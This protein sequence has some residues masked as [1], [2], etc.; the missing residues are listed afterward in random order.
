[1]ATSVGGVPE[2]V[3]Q[4]QLGR[5]VPP[6]KPTLFSR[7]LREELDREYDPAE[8]NRAFPHYSWHDNAQ[9]ILEILQTASADHNASHPS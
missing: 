4:P 2:V 9:R 1:M 7:A 8:V 5:L 6:K 3:D